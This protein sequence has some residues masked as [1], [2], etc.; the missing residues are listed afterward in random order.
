MNI[1][2]V[3]VDKY[4]K[5]LVSAGRTLSFPLRPETVQRISKKLSV[6]CITFKSQSMLTA[7]VFTSFPNL[8]LIV[9]RTVGIDNI[10]LEY[11][12]SH[13]IAVYHIPDYGSQAVAE[14]ALA[15]ILAGARHIVQADRDVHTGKFSYKQFLGMSIG[16][17]TVGVVGT[18]KIGLA[19]IKLISAF[20]V[21]LLA[22]DVVKNQKAAH[23]LGFRYVSLT[24]LLQ[25]ADIISVHVPLLPTSK[26]MIGSKEIE[27]MKEGSILVN[28]S[29]GAVIDT[30]ALVSRLSK[31]WAVCL[32]VVE[33]E[34]KFTKHN[35]FVQS[36]NVIVSPHIGFYTDESVHK[37]AQETETC[38]LNYENRKRE[39]RI[40]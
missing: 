21:K 34:D 23:D 38:I 39:G 1:L 40:I 36:K 28:T 4:F 20:G 3:D 10:D 26:H 29:R 18:G 24:N 8:K 12:K 32:D 17:K 33:D 19:F 16:G 22:C 37:I 2:H 6:S 11:C 13:R 5:L 15:L 7:G 27:I 9:A 30:K 35:P 25:S 31:F 14:H